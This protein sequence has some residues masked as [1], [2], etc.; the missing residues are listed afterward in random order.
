MEAKSSQG[1]PSGST[2]TTNVVSD[3]IILEKS[4][5]QTLKYTPSCPLTPDMFIKIFK[6]V[7]SK[8]FLDDKEEMVEYGWD[9]GA[10]C[11]LAQSLAQYIG[12]VDIKEG[13]LGDPVTDLVKMDDTW[14][15]LA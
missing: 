2:G 4:L 12:T 14:L 7:E 13:W 9:I 11:Y 15:K 10:K 6:R 8:I 5:E 3:D 1:P